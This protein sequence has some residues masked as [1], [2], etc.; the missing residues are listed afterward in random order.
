MRQRIA[1]VVQRYGDDIV[2]GSEQLCRVV[3]ERL[4]QSCECDVITTCARDY[5]TWENECAPGITLSNG[6]RVR[7]F[8]IDAPRNID[9]F[10]ALSS[11]LLSTQNNLALEEHWIRAQGPYSTPMLSFL[12][13]N[14]DNYDVFIFFTYLYCTTY[15]GLPLVS[16]RAILV[17]TAHD[18]LPDFIF[19]ILR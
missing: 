18:E 6:V 3:A 9:Y 13:S 11:V 19:L 12:E 5:M 10:N 16:D 4:A 15:F 17:P 7:R 2:G 8:T 1:L 14:R